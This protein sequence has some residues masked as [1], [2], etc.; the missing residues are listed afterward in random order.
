M[1]PVVATNANPV[2]EEIQYGLPIATPVNTVETTAIP[3][4]RFCL[5]P[6]NQSHTFDNARFVKQME[7]K[8]DRDPT[9]HLYCQIV[10]NTSRDLGKYTIPPKSSKNSGCI[11]C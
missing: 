4:C 2:L 10:E 7:P 5:D 3:S 8:I 1:Q 9:T 11:I 6:L